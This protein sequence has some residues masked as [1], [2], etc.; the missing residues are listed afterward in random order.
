MD[1]WAEFD[2][3]KMAEEARA[4]AERLKA[5]LDA[6]RAQ[7]PVGMEERMQRNYRMMI[8]GDEYREQKEL[9]ALFLRKAKERGQ[10]EK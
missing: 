8:L 5:G 9:C 1:I 10:M 3:I 4:E 2:Y 6:L 7:K